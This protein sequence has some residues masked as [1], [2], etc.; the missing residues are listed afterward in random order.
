MRN[1]WTW[2]FNTVKANYRKNT[3]HEIPSGFLRELERFFAFL[4]AVLVVLGISMI[5]TLVLLYG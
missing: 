3:G 5:V 1:P 4:G 2:Y